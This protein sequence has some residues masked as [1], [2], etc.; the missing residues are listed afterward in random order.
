[1]GFLP[2]ASATKRRLGFLCAVNGAGAGVKSISVKSD[3]MFHSDRPRAFW[4]PDLR[5]SSVLIDTLSDEVWLVE[6]SITFCATMSLAKIG[7]SSALSSWQGGNS[8]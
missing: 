5:A 7:S 4:D 8:N 6:L 2:M 3:G 1:M